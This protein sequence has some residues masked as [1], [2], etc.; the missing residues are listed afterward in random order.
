MSLSHWRARW[1]NALGT[2]IYVLEVLSG[3]LWIAICVIEILEIQVIRPFPCTQ[4]I[5]GT[6]SQLALCSEDLAIS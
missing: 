5:E 1:S 6:C 3:L 4:G 2:L